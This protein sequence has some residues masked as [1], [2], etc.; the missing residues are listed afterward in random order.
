MKPDCSARRQR[1]QPSTLYLSS[2]PA[3]C[4]MIVFL[5]SRMPLTR[6]KIDIKRLVYTYPI[7]SPYQGDTN[8]HPPPVGKQQAQVSVAE[9]LSWH[10]SVSPSHLATYVP[11]NLSNYLVRTWAL[12]LMK[13]FSIAFPA[14]V[15]RKQ[16]Q[17]ES[18]VDRAL[19]LRLQLPLFFLWYLFNLWGFGS[20][21]VGLLPSLA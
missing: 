12:I 15:S 6:T 4:L 3:H 11:S 13:D 7:V 2:G 14:N 9:A 19:T 17:K 18:Q 1:L 8:S 5:G 16:T 21:L 20:L 10:M